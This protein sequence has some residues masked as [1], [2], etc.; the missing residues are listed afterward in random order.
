M[1]LAPF[2]TSKRTP[3]SRKNTQKTTPKNRRE[4]KAMEI[5][6]NYPEPSGVGGL[7]LSEM[8]PIILGLLDIPSVALITCMD[9]HM[10]GR[11]KESL[12]HPRELQNPLLEG[13]NPPREAPKSTPGGSFGSWSFQGVSKTGPGGPNV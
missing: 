10:Y 2:W 6:G 11:S 13:P 9:N 8:L 7:R 3:K 5:T 1:I 12:G 4:K